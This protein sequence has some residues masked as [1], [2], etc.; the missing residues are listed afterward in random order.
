MGTS[1][2]L[3]SPGVLSSTGGTQSIPSYLQPYT[4]SSSAN[5]GNDGSLGIAATTNTGNVGAL[6]AINYQYQLISNQNNQAQSDLGDQA[7]STALNQGVKLASN[8][9]TSSSSSGLLGNIGS[10]IQTNITNP[11]NAFGNSAFGL[12]SGTS[13]G[14]EAGASWTGATL[15]GVLGSA[16]A[17]YGAGGAIAGLLGENQTGGSVGGALGG[18]AGDLF[19]AAAAAWTGI[20][21]LGGPI[22]IGIG[23]LAGAVLG[24]LFGNNKPSDMTQVGGIDI[25]KGAVNPVYAQQESST[26]DKYDQNDATLRDTAQMGAG[27]LA[28]YLLA[29]GATPINQPGANAPAALIMQVGNRDGYRVD[30]QGPYNNGEVVPISNAGQDSGKFIQNVTSAVLSQYNLPDSLKTQLAN[31]NNGAFYDSGFNLQNVLANPSSIMNN[32]QQAQ[33]FTPTVPSIANSNSNGRGLLQIPANTVS[34]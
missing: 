10:A 27:N 15:S 12:S 4:V 33:T 24:G 29:N 13:A 11:I 8:S 9:A 21:A 30:L 6:P 32:P 18:V 19:G 28:Q 14:A 3:I 25:A 16:G 34:A 20:G 22:G 17:G 2:N 1:S 5:T 23:I 31:I 7:I 26:G